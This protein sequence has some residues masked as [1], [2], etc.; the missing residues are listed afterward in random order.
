[1]R[2]KRNLVSVL[3]HIEGIGTK[4]RQALWKR[5]QSLDAM[6][7]ASVEEL[8]EVEGMNYPTAQRICDFFRLDLPEK[9]EVL[10]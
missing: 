6:K 3:D 10:K 4:R 2:S 8:A 5:F 7:A 9:R 1:M